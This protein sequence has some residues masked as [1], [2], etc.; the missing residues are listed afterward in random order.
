MEFARA[1]H[2]HGAG[3]QTS[4]GEI[5]LTCWKMWRWKRR[6]NA[7]KIGATR[8]QMR[9]LL[10]EPTKISCFDDDEIFDEIWEFATPRRGHTFSIAL[11]NQIYSYGWR[12]WN[13]AREQNTQT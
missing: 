12:G 2:S 5:M 1:Q 6:F 3:V 9:A 4:S 13:L 7:L 11:K 8:E 10:G